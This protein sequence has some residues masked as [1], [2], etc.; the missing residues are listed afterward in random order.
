MG[1]KLILTSTDPAPLH[2]R[3]RAATMTA[4]SADPQ[5]LK[6]VVKVGGESWVPHAAS[7]KLGTPWAFLR[8]AAAVSA[9]TGVLEEAASRCLSFSAARRLRPA[10]LS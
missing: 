3:A 6:L 1:A 5:A 7:D 8:R 10:F 9:K 2:L 4:E